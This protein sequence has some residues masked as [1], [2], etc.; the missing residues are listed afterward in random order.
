VMEP[1]RPAA[2]SPG[3]VLCLPTFNHF[4]IVNKLLSLSFSLSLCT[5]A[6]TQ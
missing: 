6:R 3:K 1:E 2:V 5:H 4:L